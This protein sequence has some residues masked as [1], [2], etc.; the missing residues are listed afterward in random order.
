[1]DVLRDSVAL[2]ATSLLGLMAVGLTLYSDEEPPQIEGRDGEEGMRSLFIFL[3]AAKY[4]VVKPPG[5]KK[6]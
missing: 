3:D 2:G 6:T 4:T 5:R 1:M